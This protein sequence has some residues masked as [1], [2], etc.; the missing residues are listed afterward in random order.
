MKHREHNK[1]SDLD[2]LVLLKM[3]DRLAFDEI[4]R[5]YVN[6]LYALAYR[7]IKNAD[8][9]ADLVQ[10][11]FVKLWLMHLEVNTSVNIKSYLFAMTRNLILNFI[12]DNNTR[13]KHNYVIAQQR[14]ETDDLYEFAAK[15]NIVKE[16]LAA[17]DKLPSQ[18][19][20]VALYRCEGFSNMEISKMMNLSLNT[21][22]THYKQCLINLKK[23]L[24]TILNILILF[25]IRYL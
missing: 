10:Q 12:R 2:L 22:N 8:D 17:I 3:G 14:G 13:L 4:Y 9:V 19:K 5:R 20:R 7:Y 24:A 6:A 11:V 15:R 18:Q 21:I 16:L 1:M 23:E 25:I